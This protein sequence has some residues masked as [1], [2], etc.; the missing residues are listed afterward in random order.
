MQDELRR[1]GVTIKGIYICPHGWDEGCECRKPKPGMFFRAAREHH[2]DLTKTTYIGDNERDKVAAEA[3][4]TGII[5]K[6]KNETLSKIAKQI[7]K[8]HPENLYKP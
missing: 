5:L 6:K 2:F 3:A 1:H 7:I 8:T 4:G